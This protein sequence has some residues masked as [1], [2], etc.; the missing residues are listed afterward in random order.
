M[1]TLTNQNLVGGPVDFGDVVG[2][3][4]VLGPDGETDLVTALP[5]DIDGADADELYVNDALI[6]TEASVEMLDAVITA[7]EADLV[8][9]TVEIVPEDSDAPLLPHNVEEIRVTTEES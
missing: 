2:T 9:G 3:F 1:Q 8:D 5:Y 7:I 4:D 6:P